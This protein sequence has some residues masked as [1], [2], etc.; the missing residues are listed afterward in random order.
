MSITPGPWRVGHWQG[1]CHKSHAGR[2]GH[3][4]PGGADG[5]VYDYKFV[6]GNGGDYYMPGIAGPGAQQMVVTT[7]YDSLSIAWDDAKLIA[8][9]PDMAAVLER[10]VRTAEDHVAK[11]NF[12]AVHRQLIGEALT[13]LLKS[14][15]QAS[16]TG[17]QR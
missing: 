16:E 9:A 8:A 6:E 1:S 15:Y 7:C 13:A 11:A 3:P 4:G 17:E 2:E 10:I 12:V 5:C 14:G